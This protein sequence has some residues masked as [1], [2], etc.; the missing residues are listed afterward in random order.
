MNSRVQK[1][2]SRRKRDE[3]ASD[4]PE[5]VNDRVTRARRASQEAGR[6]LERMSEE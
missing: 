2:R 5:P 4:E 6:F 1:R 3:P